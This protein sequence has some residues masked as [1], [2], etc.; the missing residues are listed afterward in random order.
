MERSS[1][2]SAAGMGALVG[3]VL[4]V[5]SSWL[6]YSLVS[7][8]LGFGLQP[9]EKRE[10]RREVMVEIT[11]AY[12]VAGAGIGWVRCRRGATDEPA[13]HHV[14]R[15]ADYGLQPTSAN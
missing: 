12:T 7:P 8:I 14:P 13:E 4:G 6:A 3:A 15:T 10:M 1:C 9:K 5:A 2:V 11:A